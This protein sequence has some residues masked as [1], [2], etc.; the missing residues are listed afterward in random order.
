MRQGVPQ[1]NCTGAT[2]AFCLFGTPRGVTGTRK[3]LKRAGAF[4]ASGAPG[5]PQGS[6]GAALGSRDLAWALRVFSFCSHP[7]SGCFCFQ[8]VQRLQCDSDITDRTEILRGQSTQT[9]YTERNEAEVSQEA[10]CPSV[11]ALASWTTTQ[12]PEPILA[13]LL[14]LLTHSLPGIMYCLRTGSRSE[15]HTR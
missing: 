5:I 13:F 1:L 9:I 4:L 2:L 12:H 15:K 14:A 11:S 10:T 6:V 3:L 7:F 8:K